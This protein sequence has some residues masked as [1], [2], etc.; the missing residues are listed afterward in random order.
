[1]LCTALP[2]SAAEPI[3]GPSIFFPNAEF[4]FGS[5]FDGN[6]V[7]HSFTVENRGTQELHIINVK[8]G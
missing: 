8:P 2:L 5:T 7:E 1:M 6:R 3:Q 4:N